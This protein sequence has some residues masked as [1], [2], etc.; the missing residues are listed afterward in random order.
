MKGK[1][2]LWKLAV[3]FVVVAGI[4]FGVAMLRTNIMMKKFEGRMYPM[5]LTELNDEDVNPEEWGKS[6]PSQFESYLRTQ[7]D[8]A[9]T[10]YG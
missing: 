7:E 6:F 2:G 9:Y 10:A 8:T 4:S 5:M 1:G 3:L